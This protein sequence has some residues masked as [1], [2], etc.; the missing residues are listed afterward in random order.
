MSLFLIKIGESNSSYPHQILYNL[1]NYVLKKKKI[2]VF[3]I[4]L[5]N[6][7]PV[8][9]IIQNIGTYALVDIWFLNAEV[10]T[11]VDFSSAFY[12]W[13]WIIFTFVFIYSIYVIFRKDQDRLQF[14]YFLIFVS[15]I[16]TL[17]MLILS[18]W[19][20]RVTYFTVITLIIV[21]VVAINEIIGNKFSKILTAL[22]CLVIVYYLFLFLLIYTVNEKRVDEIYAQ[23]DEGKK[24]IEVLK[25]PVR[26]LWNNN[27]PGDYFVST[28]KDYLGLKDNV[29]LDIYRL[30]YKEYVLLLLK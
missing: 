20:D 19:G 14:L 6:I 25:N 8:A 7:V 13:Y 18:T 15:L 28:Y 12:I 24:E 9:S 23:V 21:S 27:L 3:L 17:V 16:S 1:I 22:G 30:T 2:N 29:S 11:I 5:F 4:L 10:L 26:Y